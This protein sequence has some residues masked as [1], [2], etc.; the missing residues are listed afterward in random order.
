MTRKEFLERGI[1]VPKVIDDRI[2]VHLLLGNKVLVWGNMDKD[3]YQCLKLLQMED[4][5]WSDSDNYSNF[6]LCTKTDLDTFTVFEGQ[7]VSAIYWMVP[8]NIPRN[9]IDNIDEMFAYD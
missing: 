5:S 7:V 6:R 4:L 9:T 3:D 2:K 8:H 1:Y